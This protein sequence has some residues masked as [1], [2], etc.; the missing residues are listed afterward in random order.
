[1]ATGRIKDYLPFI[2]PKSLFR[3]LP[4]CS[5]Q[6]EKT[7]AAFLSLFGS[8]ALTLWSTFYVWG[9]GPVK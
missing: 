5:I 6:M 8:S 3:A 9:Y 2:K 1:M 7:A 4:L